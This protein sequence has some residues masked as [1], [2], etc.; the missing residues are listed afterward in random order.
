MDLEHADD[1]DDAGS[2]AVTSRR[3]CVT[4][5]E[6]F[7]CLGIDRTTG[8]RSIKEGTFPLPVIRVGRLIRVPIA[9][10]RRLLEL[11]PGN[12]REPD[13]YHPSP[14]A[15]AEQSTAALRL[16]PRPELAQPHTGRDAARTHRG[17]P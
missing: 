2:D 17:P 8:Y 13:G 3:S 6:A 4:A 16:V 10:I 7:A 14:T 12:R 9:A 15:E 1:V 11:G 5:E